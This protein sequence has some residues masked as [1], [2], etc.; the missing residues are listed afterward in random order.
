MNNVELE[1]GKRYKDNYDVIWE[2]IR[3][4]KCEPINHYLVENDRGVKMVIL[5]N[6]AFG[7]SS[8]IG[9]YNPKHQIIP[10]AI[11]SETKKEPKMNSV[12]NVQTKEDRKD[13]DAEI[14]RIKSI[15]ISCANLLEIGVDQKAIANILRSV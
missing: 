11:E 14:A 7:A 12:D 10:I 1:V 9:W 2:V 6:G 13:S 8:N 3:Y 15:M 5:K 4:Y